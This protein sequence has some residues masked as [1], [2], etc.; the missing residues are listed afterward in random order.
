MRVWI[1]VIL[2]II[3][4]SSCVTPQMVRWNHS[5]KVGI[6]TVPLGIWETKPSSKL[7]FESMKLMEA[8]CGSGRVSVHEEGVFVG[9]GSETYASVN[10][11][12][13]SSYTVQNRS[14][15]WSFI[16]VDN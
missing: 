12:V 5:D 16:C 8:R 13:Y 7:R 6:V 1:L 11:G 15:Y 9:G 3:L 2:G 14:Y 4:L 10:Y